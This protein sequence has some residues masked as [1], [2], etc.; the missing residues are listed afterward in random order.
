MR[1][2][3]TKGLL[4]RL[5][6]ASALLCPLTAPPPA[7]A[8]PFPSG[9]IEIISHAAPGG[10]TEITARM[11]MIRARREL[12]R[13]KDGGVSFTIVTKRGGSGKAALD[14]LMSRPADGYTLIS[15]TQTLFYTIALGKT[16]VT[17]A[18]LIGV[19]RAMD[20]PTFIV[21]ARESPFTTIE[22]LIAASRQQPLTWGVSQTLGT[23]HV[24]LA[25][26]AKAT[27]IRFKAVPFGSGG[28]MMQAL[29]SHAI[30]ATLPNVSEARG[31][32]DTGGARPL[33]LLGE[34]RLGGYGDVPT[35]HEKG[36]PLTITTTRGYAVRAGTPPEIVARLEK[37]LLAAMKDEV[38]AGYL[39]SAGVD[40][41]AGPAG[42]KVWTR[43]I[44]DD[45]RSA[46]QVLRDLGMIATKK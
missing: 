42:S 14:Y 10:G 2:E 15:L 18:D 8:A 3:A 45:I 11:M 41:K 29:L 27:G 31:P 17:G 19:A 33:L 40:P 23:E 35:S 5:A 24:G 6:W 13:A 34:K 16:A 12:A 25:R 28:I 32:I 26:F 22:E 1:V 20:E 38:F 46:G 9:E 21:V 37:A 43:Q 30:D 7:D 44:R 36:W 4:R 39:L